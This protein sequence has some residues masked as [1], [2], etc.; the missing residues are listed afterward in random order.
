MSNNTQ[1]NNSHSTINNNNNNDNRKRARPHHPHSLDFHIPGWGNKLENLIRNEDI[2]INQ[3]MEWLQQQQQQN[4]S[5]STSTTPLT[6]TSSTTTITTTTTTTTTKS[7]PPSF[8][9]SPILTFTQHVG[10]LK[11]TPRT[12]WVLRGVKNRIESVAEHSFRT[13]VLCLL[14]PKELNINIE[15]AVL[16]ALLHDLAESITGDLIPNTTSEERKHQNELL[17]MKEITHGLPSEIQERIMNL[18][19]EYEERMTK[20]A[21]LVKDMDRFDMVLQAFTYEQEHHH[22]NLSEFFDSVRGKFNSNGIVHSWFNELEEK[23]NQWFITLKQQN[24]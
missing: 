6:P 21:I 22:D 16:M 24:R 2:T 18:W 14:T 3:A 1:G 4:H 15:K 19:Y 5:T 23:R 10:K 17:A 7:S 11:T 20:E 8:A 12:G 13:A 9:S